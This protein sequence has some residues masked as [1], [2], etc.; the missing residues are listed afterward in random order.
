MH[1][2][3]HFS[4]NCL[5]RIISNWMLLV[6]F[7]S[8]LTMNTTYVIAR[9]VNLNSDISLRVKILND[10]GLDKRLSQLGK[11]LSSVGS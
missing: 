2:I 4:Q 5:L 3:M 1:F 11:G 8:Y 10:Q 6:G 7:G 9:D